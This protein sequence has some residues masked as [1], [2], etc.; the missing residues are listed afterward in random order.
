M[1]G[2][3]LVVATLHLAQVEQGV[4]GWMA[5]A[6]AGDV[7]VRGCGLED[8]VH[9]HSWGTVKEGAAVREGCS[10]SGKSGV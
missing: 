8:N 2:R 6:F 1:L 10:A 9:E 7:G 5:Y 4:D 3:G